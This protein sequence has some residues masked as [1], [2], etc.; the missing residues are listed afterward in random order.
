MTRTFCSLLLNAVQAPSDRATATASTLRSG[1][2][3]GAGRL[4][5]AIRLPLHR[6][7]RSAAFPSLPELTCCA[8]FYSIWQL[9]IQNRE[10]HL[11]TFK[12]SEGP[13]FE[14]IVSDKF[15]IREEI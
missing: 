11:L 5:L 15:S 9:P 13:T 2:G 8:P 14:R 12:V 3:S 4:V 1:S 7:Y 10:H 6:L